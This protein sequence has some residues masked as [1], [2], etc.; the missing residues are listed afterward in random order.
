MRGSDFMG[1]RE[2]RERV[3]PPPP[4]LFDL[5]GTLADTIGDIAA[6]TN[7]VRVLAGLQP[8]PIETVRRCIG[9]G[10]ATLLRRALPELGYGED[11]ARWDELL[12]AYVAHHDVQCTEGARLYPGVME[13]VTRL[14]DEGHPLAVVTN[15]PE[16][17]AVVVVRHLGLS[18]LFPVV[19]GGDTTPHK[20]PHPA[21]LR[22]AIRRLALPHEGDAIPGTMVGDGEPDLLA[23]K[24][25]SMRTVACL[26]GYGDPARLRELRPDAFWERFGG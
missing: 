4:F 26:Y 3:P 20:K 13:F 5:D 14:R 1:A 19:V 25:L 7:H 15:K 23:A 21:P 22:E 16:R 6:S 9:R 10:A 2:Y 17:F 12:R 18:D 8:V 24:A 11:D